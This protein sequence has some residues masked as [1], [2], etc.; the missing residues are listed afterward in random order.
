MEVVVLAEVVAVEVVVLA[1]AVIAMVDAMVDVMVD[2]M[3]ALE[4]G[5]VQMVTVGTKTLR[6]GM[7]VTV[8]RQS[9]LMELV[10]VMVATVVVVVAEEVGDVMVEAAEEEDMEDVGAA[11]ED[12][13]GEGIDMEEEE[14]D[15]TED[16]HPSRL[17]HFYYH[18]FTLPC[19]D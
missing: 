16:L 14:T 8:V 17:L 18:S 12:Q 11:V 4:T 9:V 10:V 6:G 15:R 1:E 7:S 19:S 13:T 5:H 2:V 3:S